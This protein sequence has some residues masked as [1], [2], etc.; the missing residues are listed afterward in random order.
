MS[1]EKT[2]ILLTTHRIFAFRIKDIIIKIWF[3]TKTPQNSA[4]GIYKDHEIDIENFGSQLKSELI[5]FLKL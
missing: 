4:L 2:E 5:G 3:K 1:I